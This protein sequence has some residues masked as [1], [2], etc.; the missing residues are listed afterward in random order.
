MYEPMAG[1][2]HDTSDHLIMDEQ[3]TLL[4]MASLGIYSL[5]VTLLT[6]KV[7]RLLFPTQDQFKQSKAYGCDR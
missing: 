3:M 6:V 1:P 7:L 5:G 4:M 2:H